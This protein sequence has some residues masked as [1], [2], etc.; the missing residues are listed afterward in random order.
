[1]AKERINEERDG[2]SRKSRKA[3]PIKRPNDVKEI[4]NR[5]KGEPRNRHLFII[6]VNT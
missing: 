3:E 2:E 1:M 5:L 4:V 6:V